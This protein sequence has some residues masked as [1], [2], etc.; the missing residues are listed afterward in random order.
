MNF[1]PHLAAKALDGSKTVTRRLTSPNPNS[2]WYEKS[3]SL[4]VGRSYAVCPGRGKAA[5]GRVVVRSVEL[6]ELAE[7]LKGDE[8]QL[9]GFDDAKEFFIAWMA[10][11]HGWDPRV[12]VWRIGFE[13]EGA[14]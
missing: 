10:I 7:V 9:E 12:L 1:R 4:V 3:C 5:I 11:N 14:S 8:A 2:P 6:Q 13:V